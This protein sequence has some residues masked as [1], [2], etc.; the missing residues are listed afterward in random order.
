MAAS[1]LCRRVPRLHQL[2]GL[3]KDSTLAQVLRSKV[4]EADDLKGCKGEPHQWEASLPA[5]H[6]LYY[7]S[8]SYSVCNFASFCNQA[9]KGV[10]PSTPAPSLWQQ[11]NRYSVN[12]LRYLSSSSNARLESAFNKD[13]ESPLPSES[14]I[15]GQPVKIDARAFQRCRPEY[16]S[17]TVD[18]AQRPHPVE[19][20]KVMPLLQKV[21]VLKGGMKPSDISQLFVQLSHLESNKMPLLKGH[22][23]FI[24]L[25]QYTG[26]HLGR[27][28]NLQLIEVLRSL[29]WLEI[30]GAHPALRRYDAELCFRVGQMSLHQLLLTADLWRC[31]GRQV[32]QFLESLYSV[33]HLHH[34]GLM[35]VAELVQL[36]YIMG[37]G[38]K[39]PM[40][41]RHPVEQLLLL[42]L[43]KLHPEEIGAVFLAL[44]KSQTLISE[45][46]VTCVVEK[47][48][49]Y[50]GDM[51]NLAIVNVLK[52]LR[53]SHL[54]HETWLEN[55]AQEVP[56]RVHGMGVQGLMH[57]ALAFSALHWQNDQ[58]LMA[59]AERVPSVAVHCRSKDSSKLLWAFGNFGFLPDQSPSFYPSL[60][61]A[62]RQRKEEFLK[63]PAHLLSG[64]LGLIFVSQFPE[65]LIALALSPDFVSIALQCTDFDLKKDLFTVDGA[66]ALELPQW[67]GPQLSCELR[68]ELWKLAMSDVCQK[69]EVLEAESL[70]CD[71]LGGEKFVCK[72]MILP[73]TRSID[74]EVHLD[75]SGQPL[76]VNPAS[77]THTL[78]DS[79][80]PSHPEWG[81]RNVGV[82]ISDELFAQLTTKNRT[83][84]FSSPAPVNKHT[85][86]MEEPDEGWRKFD[87]RLFFGNDNKDLARRLYRQESKRPIKLAIQ[88]SNR[89]QFCYRSRQLMGLHS[90]KRRQ[91][92]LAGYQVVELHFWEWFPLLRKSRTEKRAYLHC[93]IYNSLY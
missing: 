87:T 78:Q 16:A 66:V 70:L 50:V 41:L 30:P 27:F 90:M 58:I 38:R 49:S 52:Y 12:G 32:P 57:V 17:I 11:G 7:I 64:L 28:T 73:H 72:R 89:N 29:V 54:H 71:L 92:K 20:Q 63:Y 53:F 65:D 88:V 5:Q 18:L 86:H 46:A 48:C 47:A 69:V 24:M 83:R 79:P 9:E 8:R 1:V 39:F 34:R 10:C 31:I 14:L 68:E 42:H 84:P 21:G 55:M 6:G 22:K 44:F 51:S 3:S 2:P 60:I 93:K 15:N 74:L 19:W 4:R 13:S 76:P 40:E 77:N 43:D 26:E 82:T 80:V 85:V 35:E 36:L 56:R 67:T 59:I 81:R 61:E 75:A 23:H 25:V 33:I 37:E 45:H 91:L 62:L